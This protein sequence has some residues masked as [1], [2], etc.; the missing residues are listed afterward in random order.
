MGVL[1]DTARRSL[2]G[3]VHVRGGTIAF[4]AD[5]DAILARESANVF[6]IPSGDQFKFAGT[7]AI[8]AGTVL[9]GIDTNLYRVSSQPN[10]L[11]TDDDINI[12][13]I[14]RVTRTG[15]TITWGTGEVRTLWDVTLYRGAADQLTTDDDFR[16]LAVKLGTGG[17]KIATTGGGTVIFASDT[18]NLYWKAAGQLGTDGKFYGASDIQSATNLITRD[19]GGTAPAGVLATSGGLQVGVLGGTARVYFV[20]GGTMYQLSGV[21]A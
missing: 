9:W 3:T 19:A 16:A 2:G 20:T 14:F 12:G 11:R 5:M 13:D 7:V 6:A 8:T 10:Q 17:T 1:R 21:A 4:G 18:T 15:G